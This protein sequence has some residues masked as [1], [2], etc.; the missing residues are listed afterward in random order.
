MRLTS[1]QRT[2]LERLLDVYY[3]QQGQPIH[4]TDLARALGVAN[5]TAYEMLRAL[6][7]KGYASSEYR[8]AQDRVG[9]GR[10]MVLFRPTLK[11]L[12]TFRHLLG[13]DARRQEWDVVRE[14]LLRRLSAAG[15]PDDAQLLGDLLAAIPESR[16]PLSYCGHVVAASLLSIKSQLLGRVQDW[17][18]FRRMERA[19]SSGYD[20]LELLPGFALGFSYAL[21]G[22]SSWLT[23]LAGCL[24][25]YQ[26]C[27]LQMDEEGRSRLLHF[28]REMLD[29]LRASAGG[30]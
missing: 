2:C 1:R 7:Q 28:S 15:S 24:E 6:E 27:L 30:T 16:D 9:P 23:R 17:S 3:R 5:S 4:Y 20:A 18:I 26:A 13:E 22:N 14:K 12:R 21:Q 25:R 29:A 8:L 19:G 10:S 11:T